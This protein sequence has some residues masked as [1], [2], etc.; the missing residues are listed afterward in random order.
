[1]CAVVVSIMMLQGQP[2]DSWVMIMDTIVVIIITIMGKLVMLV[3]GKQLHT[4]TV[5]QEYLGEENLVNFGK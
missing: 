2:V 5:Q 1:M 4:Y 3:C